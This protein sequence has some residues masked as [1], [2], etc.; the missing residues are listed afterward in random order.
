MQK[1][2]NFTVD[3]NLTKK[4][5]KTCDFSHRMI[6]HF[7]QKA[8]IVCHSKWN[9][10]LYD[11]P[12]VPP[13]VI[14][15]SS[16]QKEAISSATLRMKMV[17]CAGCSHV[18]NQEFNP[19]FISYDHNSNL[20]YNEGNTWKAYQDE[21]SA[22][23]ITH[24]QLSNKTVVE[25]GTGQGL[26]LKRFN[27]N[28]NK[29]IGFEPGID[30]LSSAFTSEME[31]IHDYFTPYHLIDIKPDAIICRHVIEHLA[32]PFDF[33]HQFVIAA[34]MNDLDFLFFAEVPLID[35]ALKQRRINDFLYE[36]VSHFTFLSFATLF[37]RACFEI[38]EHEARYHEE[39]V[40]IVARPTKNKLANV[41][42]E[43]TKNFHSDI[44]LQ[45]ELVK[46][47]IAKWRMQNKTFALWGAT[48]KG[49]ALTNFFGLNNEL[50]PLVYDSDPRKFGCYVPGTGQLIRDPH[51]L[52]EKPCDII[53]I[54]TN[55]HARDIEKEIREKY[56]LTA[57]L[58]VYYQGSIIPL[59]SEM[60]L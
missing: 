44:S 8:C 18:F 26:F 40:T 52:K 17:Q 14:G 35:K 36:H 47:T 56:Q 3:I 5:E 15:L 12:N 1:D 50:A 19:D 13:S 9:F 42:F 24:Y 25:I 41:L 20:V 55:W 31:I 34:Q 59:A 53:L 49:S 21:L 45:N 29:C 4:N 30:G 60:D 32:N 22:K 54:C 7:S 11:W 16:S 57:Q 23:W 33:L 37:E 10:P 43:Q 46:E 27:Q 6:P 51:E 2:Q 48:G 28:D 58:Y 38:L 39:V